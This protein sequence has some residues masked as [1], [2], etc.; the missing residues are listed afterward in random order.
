[1]NVTLDNGYPVVPSKHPEGYL[2]TSD[3]CI[4]VLPS[5]VT[6]TVIALFVFYII[7]K[8]YHGMSWN[9]YLQGNSTAVGRE[10][11]E[12]G[13]EDIPRLREGSFGLGLS[14]INIE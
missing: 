13:N 10:T 5:A 4:I 7:W 12:G 8:T 11:E 3:I 2:T 6:I 14:T 9:V 1:M